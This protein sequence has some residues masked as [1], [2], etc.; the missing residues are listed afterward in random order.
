MKNKNQVRSKISCFYY[1]DFD[2]CLALLYDNESGHN[3]SVA[4]VCF[5]KSGE[6]E[7]LFSAGND[8][9]LILWNWTSETD[10]ISWQ[11][12]L[13]EKINALTTKLIS[14]N[15]EQIYIGSETGIYTLRIT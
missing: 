6:G 2:F 12:K 14:G 8:R 3:F 1:T 10:I 11:K 4:C 15:S 9:K 13:P 7:K 5:A